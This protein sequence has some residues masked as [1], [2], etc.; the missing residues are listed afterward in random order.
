[1][2]ASH[3][4]DRT[5]DADTASAADASQSHDTSK[6]TLADLVAELRL[7]AVHLWTTQ[8]DRLNLRFKTLVFWMVLGSVALTAIAAATIT[9][10]SLVVI[11]LAGALSDALDLPDW[12]GQLLAPALLAGT[13]TC[14]VLIGGWRAR[15][16]SLG[17]ARINYERRREHNETARRT[18]NSQGIEQPIA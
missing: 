13:C 3:R 5:P 8:R 9:A 4:E 18:R 1:M 11:G 16:A 10:A 2:I 14:V 17:K 15:R 12:A 7:Q 6:Q